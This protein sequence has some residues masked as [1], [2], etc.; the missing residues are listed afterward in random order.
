MTETNPGRANT[1][2]TLNTTFTSPT[3]YINVE[4]TWGYS[5]AGTRYENQTR[6]FLP[7]SAASVSSYCSRAMNYPG[8]LLP[9]DYAN[10][11]YPVPARAYR[12]QPKCFTPSWSMHLT[13]S[14]MLIGAANGTTT[15]LFTTWGTDTASVAVLS[16]YPL[17]NNCSTIWDD[18]APALSVP[19]ELFAMRPQQEADAGGCWFI[20]NPNDL[21]YDPPT[22]LTQA[23]SAV[24]P[25]KPTTYPTASAVA[26]QPVAAQ[27][28][29]SL[30]LPTP[31]ATMGASSGLAGTSTVGSDKPAGT[32]DPSIQQSSGETESV[33]SEPSTGVSTSALEVPPET[34][35]Y[36]EPDVPLQ[37]SSTVSIP[38]ASQDTSSDPELAT[39]VASSTPSN[40]SGSFAHLSGS[41]GVD[42][43]EASSQGQDP[44]QTAVLAA[45]LAGGVGAI[46]ASIMGATSITATPVASPSQSTSGVGVGDPQDSSPS[47][48]ADPAGIIL[49]LLSGTGGGDTAAPTAESI[50][51][52]AAA[53]PP[54]ATARGVV[55]T[56][57]VGNI[58]T[59]SPH[60]AGNVVLGTST[61][62]PGQT[63]SLSGIGAVIAGS[64]GV[65]VSGTIFPYS[66]LDPITTSPPVLAFTAVG[67]T[68]VPHGTTAI[69]LA[70]SLLLTPGR[71]EVTLE[72]KTVYLAA[73]GSYLVVNH[74]LT[75]SPHYG[76]TYRSDPVYTAAGTTL[77]V[78]S[79][80]PIPLA[81]S[82]L[83]TPG[84]PEVTV[85]AE[86][87]SLAT[88]G[89][90]LVI[91][92]TLTQSPHYL[93]ATR[94]AE[95]VQPPVLTLLGQTYTLNPSAG[96]SL[97][98]GSTNVVL[99]AGGAV[100]V[101][102]TTLSLD[103]QESF[104][105]VDGVTRVL[106]T[107][108]T[109]QT[110]SGVM[111]GSGVVTQSLPAFVEGA[112]GSQSWSGRTTRVASVTSSTDL[113]GPASSSAAAAAGAGK[114]AGA[115]TSTWTVGWGVFASV[116][117][118][119]VLHV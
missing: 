68:F 54:S 92:H 99:S 6:I 82:L 102:G 55:L 23:A 111:G 10:F 35:S 106:G 22:A 95:T 94:S 114:T 81:S 17:E 65:E 24:G 118:M 48:S 41:S 104:V 98:L 18:Y 1:I 29:S 103:P 37:G 59:F 78:H 108:T 20:P 63:T 9:V 100:M 57:T 91:N 26:V 36:S 7:Q 97:H 25:S 31:V 53:A 33:P 32:A 80:N 62:P 27:P 19:Q 83:L 3:V 5:S 93:S 61:V 43:A 113:P 89:S 88:S 16:W 66:V 109:S 15:S 70:S 28:A 49:S 67:T 84:G 69:P 74:T 107:A 119:N 112:S 11:N 101:S 72:D 79:I 46:I 117:T 87:L 44:Q 30:T 51:S 2:V 21:L 86:T 115:W 56:D 39:E 110:Q 64:S 85:G 77:T 14:T 73:S 42:T 12:C 47:P 45:P 50:F 116:V 76:A 8:T 38:E 75:Q 13:L 58:H 4:G 52:S 60:S 90:Y 96:L 71:P 34:A 105:V 40:G